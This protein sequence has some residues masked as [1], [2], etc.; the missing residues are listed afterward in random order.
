[1]RVR[2]IQILEQSKNGDIRIDYANSFKDEVFRK[3]VELRDAPPS[4][5]QVAPNPYLTS[6]LTINFQKELFAA[7]DGNDQEYIKKLAYQIS[8][9]LPPPPDGGY[10]STVFKEIDVKS[11]SNLSYQIKPR[12]AGR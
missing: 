3:L 6:S 10:L 5:P 1:M 2:F 7:M 12:G 9:S 11:L 4:L 8:T